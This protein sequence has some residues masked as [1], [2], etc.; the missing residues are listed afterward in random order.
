MN[1]SV[2]GLGYVG[3]VTSACLAKQGYRVIGV[4]VHAGKVAN[5][6]AGQSPIIEAGLDDLMAEG[7][8]AGRL[9]AT[10]DTAEAIRNTE[11]VIGVRVI[12]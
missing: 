3:A 11:G 7:H 12:G 5:L 6:N 8:A 4:D 10:T 1:I 9:S 2:F